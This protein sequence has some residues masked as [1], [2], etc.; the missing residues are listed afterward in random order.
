MNANKLERK[1]NGHRSDPVQEAVEFLAHHAAM[2][3][4]GGD[5]VDGFNE[6]GLLAKNRRNASDLRFVPKADIG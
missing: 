6:R 4:G 1:E 5:G 2:I 3:R